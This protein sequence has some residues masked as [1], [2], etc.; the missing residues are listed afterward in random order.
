MLRGVMRSIAF[1]TTFIGGVIIY[2]IQHAITMATLMG[3]LLM[4]FW[5]AFVTIILSLDDIRKSNQR[6]TSADA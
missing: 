2:M 3:G 1:F 4:A 5:F 6:P